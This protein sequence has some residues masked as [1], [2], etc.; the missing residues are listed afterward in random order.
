MP[1][2]IC[3]TDCGAP[4]VQQLLELEP[5]RR[6]RRGFS[7]AASVVEQL[8]QRGQRTPHRMDI[9]DVHEVQA[10][11]PRRC[12]LPTAVCTPPSVAADVFEPTPPAFVRC[13]VGVGPCVDDQKLGAEQIPGVKTAAKQR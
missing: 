1:A 7:T 6:Y 12:R 4:T 3:R 5:S 13:R 11:C 9:V 8:G 2:Y 10:R